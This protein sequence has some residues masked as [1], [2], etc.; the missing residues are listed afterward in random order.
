MSISSTPPPLI[1][2]SLTPEEDDDSYPQSPQEYEEPITNWIEDSECQENLFHIVSL[3]PEET[4]IDKDNHCIHTSYKLFFE[5]LGYLT[6]EPEPIDPS[7]DYEKEAKELS[8]Q[9]DN[10]RVVRQKHVDLSRLPSLEYSTKSGLSSSSSSI[11]HEHHFI[12]I[13]SPHYMGIPQQHNNS[14]I[15]DNAY[16]YGNNHHHQHASS[17]E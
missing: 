15:A 14:S 12:D 4:I 6:E 16:H 7:R 8:S 3:T 17:H 11:H 2:F 1:F 9:R 13:R 5:E 10:K